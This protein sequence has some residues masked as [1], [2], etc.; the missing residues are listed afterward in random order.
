MLDS[1][2]AFFTGIPTSVELLAAGIFVAAG[3]I[4]RMARTY[5]TYVLTNPATGQVYIG[6]T[7]GY[8]DALKIILRRMYAHEYY[9]LGFTEIEVD[10][11]MQGVD[12]RLAIR[13][14]EQHLI[15]YYGGIGHPNVANK[16]R[17]VATFNI[18]RRKMYRLSEE[19]FGKQID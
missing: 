5:I 10:R 4:D 14:R 3:Y 8:G 13:G 2:L 16:I 12:A 7:S 18:N 9:K 17:A 15:D 19:F 6:R 1:I 11:A